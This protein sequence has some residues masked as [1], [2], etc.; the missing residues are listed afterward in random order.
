MKFRRALLPLC[1]LVILSGLALTEGPQDNAK[2]KAVLDASYDLS[3]RLAPTDS[4]YYYFE[5]STAMLYISSGTKEPL[6]R[7]R[8]FLEMRPKGK[9]EQGFYHCHIKSYY[10]TIGDAKPAKVDGL[11]S[12]DY[13][14]APGTSGYNDKGELFGISHADFRRASVGGKALHKMEAFTLYMG[15][16]DFHTF[17]ALLSDPNVRKLTRVGQRAMLSTVGRELPVDLGDVVLKGSIQTMGA[18]PVELKGLR[19]H[20]DKPCV[21]YHYSVESTVSL[22]MEPV[23]GAKIKM[24]G[25]SCFQGTITA[26]IDTGLISAADF[27]EHIIGT[28]HLGAQK[29]HDFVTRRDG[30]L[31]RISKEQYEREEAP[32]Q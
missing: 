12:Y 19:I 15:L 7:Y 13:S 1:A 25:P 20:H 26:E 11:S 30:S 18:C 24:T 6:K 21:L 3:R 5:S 23:P 10:L 28:N 16:I 31:R 9:E 32:G 27:T 29:L 2:A 17:E 8:F 14:F 4:R 22:L